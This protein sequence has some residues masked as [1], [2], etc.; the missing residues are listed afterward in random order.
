MATV[1]PGLVYL[2]SLS[3]GRCALGGRQ[4]SQTQE[5]PCLH[6]STKH[7]LRCKRTRFTS[8]GTRSPPNTA[9]ISDGCRQRARQSA[10]VLQHSPLLPAG[11]GLPCSPSSPRSL[12]RAARPRREG[13][14]LLLDRAE[15]S[16]GTQ[17]FLMQSKGEFNSQ[18]T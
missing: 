18:S 8:D 7:L 5:S 9:S 6:H 1:P 14:P 10:A 17:I 15:S 4:P 16:P 12:P 3:Y 13:K 2:V 11:K